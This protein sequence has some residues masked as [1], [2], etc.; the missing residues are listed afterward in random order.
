MY[1]LMNAKELEIGADLAAGVSH[2]CTNYKL[3]HDLL[4]FRHNNVHLLRVIFVFSSE[5]TSVT[6]LR[7]VIRLARMALFFTAFG[8]F[9]GTFWF[10]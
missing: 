9:I 8:N 4:E 3:G 5:K 10:F 2:P 1:E 7:Q 6:N